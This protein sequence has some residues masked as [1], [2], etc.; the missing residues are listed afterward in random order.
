MTPEQE[1]FLSMILI[2]AG[3]ALLDFWLGQPYWF[4]KGMIEGIR[5]GGEIWDETLNLDDDDESDDRVLD[6]KEIQ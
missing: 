3:S 2:V 6:A 4:A 1:Y 5:H